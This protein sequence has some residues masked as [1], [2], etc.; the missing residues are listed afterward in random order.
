MGYFLS[1]QLSNIDEIENL[2]EIKYGRKEI[3]Y[4]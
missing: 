2:I 1:G 4:L 3:Y